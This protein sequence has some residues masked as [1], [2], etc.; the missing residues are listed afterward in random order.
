MNSFVASLLSILTRKALD[1]AKNYAMKSARPRGEWRGKI[2]EFPCDSEAARQAGY[3]A[4]TKC[5][6]IVVRPSDPLRFR[7][8]SGVEY[9]VGDGVSDGGST[10]PFLRKPVEAWADLEP[11]GTHKYAFYFHDAMYHDGGV[12]ARKDGDAWRW[13]KLNRGQADFLFLQ[14]LT[15]TGRNAEVFAIWRAVRRGGARSW[16]RARNDDIAPFSVSC[17]SADC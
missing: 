17:N 16:K 14:A 3:S 10:P 13:L 11:F 6:Y 4:H 7:H 1:Y 8:E 2:D 12:F 5:R 9:L 15:V